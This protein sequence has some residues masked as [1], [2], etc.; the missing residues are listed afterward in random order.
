MSKRWIRVEQTR[1]PI[2]RPHDQRATLRGDVTNLLRQLDDLRSVCGL[3]DLRRAIFTE[4]IE[5]IALRRS[6]RHRARQRPPANLSLFR[7]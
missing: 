3:V 5:A 4:G 2:R 6:W 7:N 1:S